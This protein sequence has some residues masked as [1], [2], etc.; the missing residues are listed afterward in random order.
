MKKKI[1]IHDPYFDKQEKISIIKVLESHSWALSKGNGITPKLELKF[2]N[3]V[4]SKECVSVDS[5]SSALLL[6]MKL[7]DVKNK[8]VI[9]PSLSH[10]SLA[11]SITLNGGK[12]I[13]VDVD[14]KTLCLDPNLAKKAIN[15]KT[16]A[17]CPVHFGGV[18]AD[19]SLFQRICKEKNL[20][21]IEDAALAMGSNYNDKKIGQ[22]SDFVCFS[23]HPVKILSAPK[24]GMISINSKNSK[25]IKKKLYALRNS[26]IG[27]DGKS[28]DSV[29]WNAYMNEFSAAICLEQLKKIK[30]IISKRNAI[31]KRYYQELDFLIRMPYSKDYAYNFYWIQ[32]KNQ[33]SFVKKMKE[34][35]IEVANYHTPIHMTNFYQ[36]SKKLKHTEYAYDRMVLLPTHPGLNTEDITNIID[37]TK[38]FSL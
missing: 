25:S 4:R 16:K 20:K 27:T 17:I 3:F 26:G 18:P 7:L 14:P 22:H 31:S 37:L 24:G 12:P 28:V 32:V 35:N 15:K 1:K 23:F 36:N 21:L 33:K 38:K 34:K 2:K 10:V 30:K 29:G 6:T 13:F 19:I 5:A 11:H 9:I 8:E